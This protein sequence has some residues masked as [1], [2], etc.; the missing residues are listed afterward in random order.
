MDQINSPDE[1][2][3]IKPDTGTVIEDDSDM[4]IN[5]PDVAEPQAE[6]QA[7]AL[8][9]A[10]VE[11]ANE[12][13][14]A[15]EAAA[16]T[17]KETVMET[18][19]ET[20]PEAEVP[21][22]TVSSDNF[23]ETAAENESDDF[24][25]EFEEIEREEQDL[26]MLEEIGDSIVMQVDAE[27]EN[28][29][30]IPEEPVAAD[31][32]EYA[33]DEPEQ[34]DETPEE[35]RKHRGFFAR[36]PWWGYTVAGVVIVIALTIIWI[37]ATKSG[38]GAMV[39][40]GSQY[41]ANQVTYQPVEPV[42]HIEVPDEITEIDPDINVEDIEVIP[43]DFTV[44]TPEPVTPEI[45]PEPVQDP[46]SDVPAVPVKTVHNI[47]LVGEENIDSGK[48]RGRS[49]LIMIATINS[50]QK[51]VK[52]T[53]IMRDSLVAIPGYPD[54]RINAAYAIG[55]V[56][57][58]YDTLKMNLG[59]DID[60]Y[61]LVNFESFVAIVDALGGID[62]EVTADEAKYLNTTNYIANPADRK[63]VAG[64]NHMNGGQV[65][66]YCRIRHVGTANNEYSDFGR[67]S[68]Q[69]RVLSTI[70]DM[71]SGMN[72]FGLMGMAGKCLPYVTTDMDAETMEKYINMLLEVGMPGPVETFRVPISGSFSD[73]M[74]REMLVTKIDLEVNSR[75]LREFIYGR[76][77]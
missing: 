25:A 46:N 61:I 41:A 47:L 34:E 74:L 60:N 10:Q 20:V 4:T 73:V 35:D 48:Y 69:R 24:S 15:P 5:E 26:Q 33:A 16:E 38:R 42:E 14:Q 63:I 8:D 68:R 54:N 12:P 1:L 27:I 2:F 40:Y 57:L 37:A 49:D 44:V 28:S 23:K 72:Y 7:E 70:Y 32:I 39:K 36:I 52:L 59:I 53:S 75:A 29:I 18:A 21:T 55:G 19:D 56:S 51:S 13:E 3:E 50:E 43:D 31:R 64:T 45:T 58:L 77:Q 22:E 6:V 65:L 9:E 62:V 71:A 76:E 30:I 17:A 11:T 66:G 67:T